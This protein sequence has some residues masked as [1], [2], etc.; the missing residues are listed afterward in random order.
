MFSEVVVV[1]FFTFNRE[2]SSMKRL[3][4]LAI[5]GTV[6][7]CSAWQ[8]APAQPPKEITQA[9]DGSQTAETPPTRLNA[10]MQSKLEKAKLI[11]EGLT[12][13][14]YDKIASN[15]SQLKLLSMES[16]WNVL[17]TEEYEAQSDDFRRTVDLI[18]AAA[19]DKDVNRATLGYVALT[20][21]CV[22]CHSYIR[23]KQASE[24]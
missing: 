4:L 23:K 24:K 13:E 19:K 11:L 1:K 12:L 21:R 20:V 9:S 6:G 22:E 14:D 10:L 8:F 15:A 16:G 17:Q 18:A 3:A 2:S 7:L 5:I